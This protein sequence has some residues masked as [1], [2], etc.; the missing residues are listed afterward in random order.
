MRRRV[1]GTILA[2]GHKPPAGPG[3]LEKETPGPTPGQ[4]PKREP[5]SKPPVGPDTFPVRK[6]DEDRRS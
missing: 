5:K 3:D 6:P 4:T 1:D 2:V